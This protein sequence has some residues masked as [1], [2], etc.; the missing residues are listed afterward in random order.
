M[1][2]Y[3]WGSCSVLTI[4]FRIFFSLSC[5]RDAVIFVLALLVSHCTVEYLSR[6]GLPPVI[7]HALLGGVARDLS[8]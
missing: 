3:T 5:L 7:C 4:R 6:G 2:F 8:S 1:E